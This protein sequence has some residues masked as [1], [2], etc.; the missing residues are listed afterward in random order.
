[1]TAARFKAFQKHNYSYTFPITTLS[2]FSEQET[3]PS[4]IAHTAVQA[5]K[6]AKAS[7]HSATISFG[8]PNN[9]L[10]LAGSY[11]GEESGIVA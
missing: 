6:A 7:Q 10:T 8:K 5:A 11:V 4:S 1:V 2:H 3:T 9:R